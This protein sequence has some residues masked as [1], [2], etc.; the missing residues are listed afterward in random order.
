MLAGCWQ[1]KTN[2]MQFAAALYAR[3]GVKVFIHIQE[4]RFIHTAVIK[5]YKDNK[6]SPPERVVEC[7]ALQRSEIITTSRSRLN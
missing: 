6:N 4:S 2:K 5:S 3:G 7:R 1:L